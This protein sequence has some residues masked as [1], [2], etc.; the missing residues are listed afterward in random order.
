MTQH[1]RSH[2]RFLPTYATLVGLPALALLVILRV[3]NAVVAKDGTVTLLLIQIV[4][5][6]V[7]A[8]LTEAAATSTHGTRWHRTT[9]AR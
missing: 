7:A 4:V 6:L 9:E 1:Q 5:I 2:G 3:G 8:R